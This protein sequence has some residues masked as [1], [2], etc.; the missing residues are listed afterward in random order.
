M[1]STYDGMVVV[2][3]PPI[4]E[5]FEN[6]ILR[7]RLTARDAHHPRHLLALEPRRMRKSS[8]S[9]TLEFPLGR[10]CP[11]GTGLYQE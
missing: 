4:A 7:P 8:P 3:M 9:G 2:T 1:G 11:A 5:P 10:D 6:A